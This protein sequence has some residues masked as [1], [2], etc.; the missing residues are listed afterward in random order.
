MDTPITTA[1]VRQLLVEQF[2]QYAQLPIRPIKPGGVDNR[3]FRLGDAFVVRLPSAAGYAAQVEK[4]NTWLPRLAPQLPI[5]IPQP[6]VMGRP[7]LG[8]PLHWSVYEWIEGSSADRIVLDDETLTFL[9]LQLAD[10]LKALHR[11][12]AQEGPPPGVHNYHRGAS[13]SVY[14][15]E[16]RQSIRMLGDVLNEDRALRVWERAIET[17]WKGAPVWVHGDVASGNL[18]VKDGRLAAVIDFGCM[19]VG[20]PAC[21]LIIAWTLFQGRSREVFQDALALDTATWA[22]ARGWAL[23]K[24]GFELTSVARQI[25]GRKPWFD[26]WQAVIDQ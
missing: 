7:S 20:D 2:P 15:C 22:R 14:D 24:A 17:R 16:A 26:V 8:Y 11:I 19:G 9:A 1:L 18:L 25:E 6:V 21:D 5:A 4:E 12:D 3:M 13:V 10:F 23:W